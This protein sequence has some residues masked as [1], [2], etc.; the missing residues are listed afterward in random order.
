M[1][2][3]NSFEQDIWP[4]SS[5]WSLV[6]WLFTGRI[7]LYGVGP[8]G[9]GSCLYGDISVHNKIIDTYTLRKY[10]IGDYTKIYNSIHGGLEFFNVR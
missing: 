8:V 1:L 4:L 6:N 3:S 9:A 10:F 5:T 2:G 7:I